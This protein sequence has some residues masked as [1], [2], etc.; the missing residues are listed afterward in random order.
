V[1]DSIRGSTE[2]DD[3]AFNVLTGLLTNG[4]GLDLS[5]EITG[6]RFVGEH[7]RL[8]QKSKEQWTPLLS[9]GKPIVLG[10]KN[11]H[12]SRINVE[13]EGLVAPDEIG[14]VPSIETSPQT[15]ELVTGGNLSQCHGGVVN[16]EIPN[17]RQSILK[18]E[19]GRM[20]NI[21]GKHKRENID[22]IVTEMLL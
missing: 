6:N 9:R 3:T 18:F 1:K 21:I 5:C 2:K 4:E 19:D 14:M 13:F 17:L 10:L 16:H 12:K 8:H 22:I 20:S 15:K 11:A 7:E